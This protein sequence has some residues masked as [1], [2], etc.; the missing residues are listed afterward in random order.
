MATSSA[1]LRERV[2]HRVR[3]PASTAAASQVADSVLALRRRPVV[4]SSSGGSQR[5]NETGPRGEPS[6]VTASTGRPT[7][8]VASSAGFPRVAEASTKVGL[9]P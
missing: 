7:S 1:D 5:A 9:A 6:S 2:K 3:T 4:S 8:R